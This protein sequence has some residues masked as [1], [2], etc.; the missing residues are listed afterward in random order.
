MR[1]TPVLLTRWH[2]ARS[3]LTCAE[4]R[5]NAG[6]VPTS[7]GALQGGTSAARGGSVQG[8]KRAQSERPLH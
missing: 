6:G 2:P 3:L 4:P 1:K 5:I 8:R 7:G